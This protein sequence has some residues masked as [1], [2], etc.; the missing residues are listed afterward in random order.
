MDDDYYRN[1]FVDVDYHHFDNDSVEYCHPDND[2]VGNVD[3]HHSDIDF[4]EYCHPDNDFVVVFEDKN[5]HLKKM[6][7][8]QVIHYHHIVHYNDCH[9]HVMFE[10]SECL[11]NVDEND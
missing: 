7:V 1:I 11:M 5:D 6:V 8:V 10:L 2:F 3:Y 4:V 9:F